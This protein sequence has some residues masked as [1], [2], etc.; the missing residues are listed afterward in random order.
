MTTPSSDALVFLGTTGDLAHKKIFPALQAMTRRGE[1]DMP[2][3]GMARAGWTLDKLRERAR[4][5]LEQ[6]GGADADAFAK[7]SAQLRYVDGD[8][9]DPATYERLSRPWAPPRVPCITSR[10]RPV[11]SARACRGWRKPAATMM[12][13]LSSRSHSV[14]TLLPRRRS[15][16]R[17][18]RS[19]RNRR[20][21][22]S[23][24]GLSVQHDLRLFPKIVC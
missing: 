19:S 14:V 4:D 10:F 24:L 21:S 5:S 15:I 6:N 18:T 16:A 8:Y 1:L 12:R 2:V 9:R 11:C 20:R 7:L 13:A 22:G 3:I 23:I 17:C